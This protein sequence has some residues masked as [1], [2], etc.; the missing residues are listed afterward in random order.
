MTTRTL[1]LPGPLPPVKGVQSVNRTHM[2][3]KKGRTSTCVL[4]VECRVVYPVVHIGIDLSQRQKVSCP[5]GFGKDS[6]NCVFRKGLTR[7]MSLWLKLDPSKKPWVVRDPF[8]TEVRLSGFSRVHP[9]F[10]IFGFKYK[11]P[12]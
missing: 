5:T 12:C 8:W 4:G 11:Q 7:V 10:Q 2:K 3:S 9:M 1:L 6:G